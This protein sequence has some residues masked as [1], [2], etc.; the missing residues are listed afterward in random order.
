MD[1]PSCF[2]AVLEPDVHG[3]LTCP[4]CDEA[5]HNLLPEETDNLLAGTSL[6]SRQSRSQRAL[7]LRTRLSLPPPPPIPSTPST[8][9]PLILVAFHLR[10]LLPC[11]PPSPRLSQA[12]VPTLL[13]WARHA[14][15]LPLSASHTR[16]HAVAVAALASMAAKE[17]TL[18]RDVVGRC[19]GWNVRVD[20]VWEVMR[21]HVRSG[22][23]WEGVSEE[24]GQVG[25]TVWRLCVLTGLGERFGKRVMRYL[26]LER[27]AGQ[28]CASEENLEVAFINCVRMGLNEEELR[29]CV[30][31][32]RR[33]M[34]AGWW[35]DSVR[36][37]WAGMSPK[38]L[39]GPEELSR[40]VRVADMVLGEERGDAEGADVMAGVFSRI[41]QNRIDDGEQE[42]RCE[43]R[44][45]EQWGP[46]DEGKTYEDKISE[47]GVV[48]LVWTVVRRFM[49]GIGCYAG[50]GDRSLSSGFEQKRWVGLCHRSMRRVSSYVEDLTERE[51]AV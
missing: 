1:C 24:I 34:K 14:Q 30:S 16:T 37:E 48:E 19:E 7:S 10:K 51:G 42:K 47:E 27:A 3:I 41:G 29:K 8:P 35:E 45:W 25:L 49:A 5:F 9:S 44:E 50:G 12:L 46:V 17:A 11:L 32:L 43:Y 6:T 26:E 39:A 13:F 21:W 4:A 15:S 28:W 38:S 36:W 18:V 23:A 2:S 20:D 31:K 40:V 33:W 22:K